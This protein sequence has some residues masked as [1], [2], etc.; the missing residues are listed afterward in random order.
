MW[1]NNESHV[2]YRCDLSNIET[3]RLYSKKV[4]YEWPFF[5]SFLNPNLFNSRF[6]HDRTTFNF[7][8]QASDSSPLNFAYQ[9]DFDENGLMYWIGSNG[10]TSLD[11]VNPGSHN[12]VV[13]TSSEGRNLP[14]GKLEDIL[15]RDSAALNCHTNDDRRAWFAIDLGKVTIIR[16]LVAIAIKL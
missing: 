7:I 1:P 4:T 16:I 14:Y 9:S 5:S 12:L 6:D 2:I 10:K 3:E 8:K 15:N 13:V 11:W